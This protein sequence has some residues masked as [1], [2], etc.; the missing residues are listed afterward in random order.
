MSSAPAGFWLGDETGARRL[1]KGRGKERE[2]LAGRFLESSNLSD[3]ECVSHYCS[4]TGSG[5]MI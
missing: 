1:R 3:D 5:E 2:K 4:D